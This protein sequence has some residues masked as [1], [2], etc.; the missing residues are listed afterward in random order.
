M[1]FGFDHFYQKM[2]SNNL[3]KLKGAP[4]F[5]NKDLVSALVDYIGFDENRFVRD[6]K[7][8]DFK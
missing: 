6:T 3:N 5:F 1:S 4:N 8:E 2:A 7:N